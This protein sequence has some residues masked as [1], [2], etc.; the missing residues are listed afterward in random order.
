MRRRVL[1]STM[2]TSV[3]NAKAASMPAAIDNS[4]HS[5]CHEVS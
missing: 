3:E 2:A 4:G 5:Q 1:A